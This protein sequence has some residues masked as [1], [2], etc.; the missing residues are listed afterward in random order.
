MAVLGEPATLWTAFVLP[1]KDPKRAWPQLNVCRYGRLNWGIGTVTDTIHRDD[2]GVERVLRAWHLVLGQDH[3]A[4]NT[5]ERIVPEPKPS[6]TEQFARGLA[7]VVGWEVSAI[8]PD[9][10]G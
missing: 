5:D 8:L 3:F 1:A 2:A 4:F 10:Q 6:P 9:A 7:T